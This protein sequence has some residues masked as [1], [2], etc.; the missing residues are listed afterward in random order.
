MK[1]VKQFLLFACLL[2]TAAVTHS[3]EAC[4][5]ISLTPSSSSLKEGESLSF[6]VNVNGKGDFTFNW[7]ISAGTIESGQGTST[8]TINTAGLANQTITATIE[9]GGM[10]RS[11]SSAKSY[12]VEVLPNPKT[13]IIIAEN[14]ANPKML[15]SHIDEAIDNLGLKNNISTD[16]TAF[17]YLYPGSATT[18]AELKAMKAV[19]VKTFDKRLVLPFM[20]KIANGPKHKK[21]SYEIWSVPIGAEDP[22]PS[23]E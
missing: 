10:N 13:K 23:T 21:A 7:A 1:A 3:Q 11:C 4:P 8:I 14:Y 5:V 15:T 16:G 18:A 2:L 9:I 17:I 19:I 12:S 6:S 22:Q 20:Y